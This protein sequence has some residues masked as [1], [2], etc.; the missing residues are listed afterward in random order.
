MSDLSIRPTP[1][2]AVSRSE[3]TQ[4]RADSE[5][6]RRGRSEDAVGQQARAVVS[7]ARET[8]VE[9]PRNAQGISAS[10]IAR[11]GSVDLSALIDIQAEAEPIQA[12]P[13]TAATLSGYEGTA[14]S[15]SP[16]VSSIFNA[17]N[18]VEALLGD[19]LTPSI[20]PVA[21]LFNDEV[22]NEAS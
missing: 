20:D 14:T 12:D 17:E 5:A 2:S 11:T 19:P 6:V 7:E 3:Q 8:G 21:D 1:Q 16:E 4:L 10:Q 9:L 22:A 15:D 13:S 18:T